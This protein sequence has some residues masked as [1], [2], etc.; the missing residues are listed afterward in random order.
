MHW[1]D[2]PAQC[3]QDVLR[4]LGKHLGQPS[5]D[6]TVPWEGEGGETKTDEPV[7]SGENAGENGGVAEGGNLWWT[8]AAL[9][10]G[11]LVLLF[12]FV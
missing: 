7:E 1:V 4:A 9:V 3:I 10:L 12:L 6:V 11:G 2:A 8:L 5:V